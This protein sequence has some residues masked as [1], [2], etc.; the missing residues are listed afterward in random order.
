MIV[1]ALQREWSRRLQMQT[2]CE[3]GHGQ[4]ATAGDAHSL[5]HSIH[6]KRGAEHDERR[7]HR[8]ASHHDENQNRLH[9]A[10]LLARCTETPTPTLQDGKL[11]FAARQIL[12]DLRV[13]S[14]QMPAHS[15][16]RKRANRAGLTLQSESVLTTSH[17]NPGS[18][19]LKHRGSKRTRSRPGSNLNFP[20]R[21][22]LKFYR[23]S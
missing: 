7:D 15:D 14:R 2:E 18:A 1:P 22:S 9:H 23:V 10:T 13:A 16:R 6:A 12:T 3:C 19:L 4:A 11:K 20:F 21:L 5:D 8:Q 17:P